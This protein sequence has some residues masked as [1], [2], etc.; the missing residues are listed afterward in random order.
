M[1]SSLL[2]VAALVAPATVGN[3]LHAQSAPP[4]TPIGRI[5]LIATTLDI[6][7][8]I[9]NNA[10]PMG[11]LDAVLGLERN[12]LALTAG[13]WSA[14]EPK[15]TRDEPR[16]DLRAGSAGLTDGSAWLQ[17]TRQSERV[18]LSA[19][20]RRD[21]YRRVGSDPAVTEIYGTARLDAGRWSHSVSAWQAV[22]GADGLYLEPSVSYHHLRNP[23]VGRV[24]EW[25]STL[26]AGLQIGERD[27]DG[28][29][30]VPGP[31][32]TGLTYISLGTSIGERFWLSGPVA[33][34]TVLGVEA[35]YRRDA[36]LRI[37]RDGSEGERVRFWVPVHIGLSWALGR[38][39]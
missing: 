13:A 3:V 17:L 35:E 9:R 39:E 28:G 38:H 23:D 16:P 8:G 26:R 15:E 37:S 20:V 36:A 33:F 24:A 27:P 18:A 19:G 12:G 2:F 22:G 1:H 29:A 30:K 31:T 25:V 6:R 14:F 10:R 4:V 32:G 11:E 34:M 21:W 7:R 5:D